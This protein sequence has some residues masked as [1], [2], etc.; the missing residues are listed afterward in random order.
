M[1]LWHSIPRLQKIWK[2]YTTYVKNKELGYKY[3][4]TEFLRLEC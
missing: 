4:N 1:F 3:K 2:G